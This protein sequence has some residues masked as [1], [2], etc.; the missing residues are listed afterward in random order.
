MKETKLLHEVKI[1]TTAIME[2]VR[3]A[4]TIETVEKSGVVNLSEIL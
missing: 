2:R 1:V 3:L 4:A